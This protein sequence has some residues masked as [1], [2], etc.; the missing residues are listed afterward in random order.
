MN[1]LPEKINA[2][3]GFKP[4]INQTF[5]MGAIYFLGYGSAGTWLGFFNL[6]LQHHGFSGQ[7]VGLIMGAQQALLF[8]TVLFWGFLADRFGNKKML[9]LVSFLAIFLIRLIPAQHSFSAMLFMMIAWALV[10]HPIGTLADSLVVSQ[11]KNSGK[12]SFAAI[13]VWGSVGWAVANL[14]IG[15][16]LKSHAVSDIFLIAFAC[17][18]IHF[19]VILFGVRKQK[20][21]RQQT[22]PAWG[23]LRI[24]LRNKRLILFLSILLLYGIC[25]TPINLFINL[26]FKEL[27]G[28][29]QIVGLAFGLNAL[30][31]IP[32]FFLA[33]PLVKRF[34][35]LRVIIFSMFITLLRLAAYGRL[36]NPTSALYLS[37]LNGF[38]FSIFWVATVEYLHAIVP[39]EW[40]AT[41]QALLWAFHLGAGLTLG[42]IVVGSLSDSIGM[43]AVMTLAAG[44][45]LLVLFLLVLY[46]LQY[47]AETVRES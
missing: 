9:A 32:L 13:R 23:E 34:G 1:R 46:F 24:L 17:Y 37:L 15:F 25:V 11:V 38:S 33:I 26:Y 3:H 7:E 44:L 47:E 35:P 40:R 12:S 41:G 21:G 2:A 22:K 29:Y 42:N 36:Q 19:L 14:A 8:F 10:S 6:F 16:F 39:Q 30:A 28:G 31:E 27:G 18:F 43:R 20:N 45:V 5:I 4:L